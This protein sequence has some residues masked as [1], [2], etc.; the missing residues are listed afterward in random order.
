M[1]WSYGTDGIRFKRKGT[2]Q[3]FFSFLPMYSK[4][5]P[6]VWRKEN[7]VKKSLVLFLLLAWVMVAVSCSKSSNKPIPKP[8]AKIEDSSVIIPVEVVSYSW[9]A[10]DGYGAPWEVMD[11]KDAVPVPKKS[12]I[13]IS[14]DKT[15]EK[16]QFRQT[17]NKQEFKNLDIQSNEIIAPDKEGVYVYSFLVKWPEGSVDYAIKVQVQ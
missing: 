17:L 16:V 12:S 1:A 10:K 14:F 5:Y 8:V 6:E 2:Q 9:G 13:A 4:K 15:P 3:I 11:N 7:L